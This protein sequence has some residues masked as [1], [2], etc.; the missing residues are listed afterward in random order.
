VKPAT[1]TRIVLVLAA[2]GAGAGWYWWQHRVAPLPAGFA[3]GN[4]RIEAEEVNVAT[5][6]AGRVDRVLVHEGDAVKAG[7]EVARM[8]SAEIA[9]A[10]EQAEATERQAE[11]AVAEAR[12]QIGQRQSEVKLAEIS[13]DRALTLFQK[14]NV[15]RELVDQRLAT[16]DGVRSALAAA[17]S[18]L[19]STQRAVEAAKA[20]VKRIR[21]QLDDLVLRAPRDGRVQ[22]RLAEPGEVLPAGGRV[23]TL[24]DLSDVTMTIFMPTRE[25]GR[26]RIGAEARIVL[27]AAPEY[28]IPAAVAF[29]AGQAQFTPKE[30]ETRNERE[31]LMFRIRLRIDPKLLR[32]HAARVKTGVPGEAFVRLDPAATWPDWL[33]VRLPPPTNDA[34]ADP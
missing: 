20:D 34:P 10:L 8:D 22:Y 31:K 4:G 32:L 9:A 27:D 21:S 29:V 3:R 24:L 19:T 18:R 13:F 11:A 30:V 17:Q 6:Y 14:G 26:A 2:L 1:A 28:V 12:A 16:R 15:S 23:V 25:A 5:R 33:A 7:Q